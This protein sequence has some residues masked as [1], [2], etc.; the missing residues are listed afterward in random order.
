MNQF[1][2]LPK[3]VAYEYAWQFLL[4]YLLPADQAGRG[5][6]PDQLKHLLDRMQE[7]ATVVNPG[8]KPQMDEIKQLLYVV[9]G[10][11]PAATH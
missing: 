6:A 2:H 7:F 3:E 10:E 9:D 4:G 8:L 5:L 1:A 11:P